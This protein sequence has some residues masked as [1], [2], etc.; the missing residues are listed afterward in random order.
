MAKDPSAH[1]NARRAACQALA[2][3]RPAVA[4]HPRTGELSW[5]NQAQ[6]FHIS[7]LDPE[8][9]AFHPHL[10]LDPRPPLFLGR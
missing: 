6:H 3:A 9:R 5:V 1:S 7:C 2:D 8:T 4:R 10:T